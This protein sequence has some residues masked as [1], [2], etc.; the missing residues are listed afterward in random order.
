M[1]ESLS[2]GLLTSSL[3]LVGEKGTKLLLSDKGPYSIRRCLSR[4][5]LKSFISA[6]F[7]VI[8]TGSAFIVVC[9][10]KFIIKP[11][12]GELVVRTVFLC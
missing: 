12:G 5:K 7:L 10:S 9:F 11:G 8:L 1:T 6:C 4:A 2:V 3:V